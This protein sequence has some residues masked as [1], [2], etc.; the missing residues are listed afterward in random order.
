MRVEDIS[1][2]NN[3]REQLHQR[4]QLSAS[5][6]ILSQTQTTGNELANSSKPITVG[7]GQLSP[8]RNLNLK[9]SS[10]YQESLSKIIHSLKEKSNAY[11]LLL[12]ELFYRILA[13]EK[14][15][16]C[17]KVSLFRQ[18]DMADKS[19]MDILSFIFKELDQNLQCTL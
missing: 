12:A 9:D 11:E 16:E 5:P 4:L 1:N 2:L 14:Q 18:P 19:D 8:D 10:G 15:V 17:L 13:F 7:G 3:Y 6:L